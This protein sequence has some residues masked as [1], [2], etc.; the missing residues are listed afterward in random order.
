MSKWNVFSVNNTTCKLIFSFCTQ[1]W[2]SSSLIWP[3]SVFA[4]Q[5]PSRIASKSWP[6]L[7]YKGYAILSLFKS[8][9]CWFLQCVVTQRI[10]DSI[11][12]WHNCQ[13]SSG[14]V[15]QTTVL[16][17]KHTCSRCCLCL[18]YFPCIFLQSPSGPPPAPST[19][20]LQPCAFPPPDA[21]LTHIWTT[22]HFSL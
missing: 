22:A 21:T 3:S 12:K 16:L 4:L 10:P 18:S 14:T 8:I 6:C 9:H 15:Q 13:T 17:H 20:Q 19:F 1:L 2:V 7:L 11:I 5:S